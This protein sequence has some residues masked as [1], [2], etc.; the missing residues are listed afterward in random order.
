MYESTLI[1][2]ELQQSHS[3]K[4]FIK[5]VPVSLEKKSLLTME[6]ATYAEHRLGQL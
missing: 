4:M 2:I 3:E 6:T 5:A 1:A